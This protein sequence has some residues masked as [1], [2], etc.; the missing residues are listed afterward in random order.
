M[1][2][3]SAPAKIALLGALLWA[4][5]PVGAADPAPVAPG[6]KD[7]AAAKALEMDGDCAAANFD[8]LAGFGYMPPDDGADGKPVP[9]KGARTRSRRTSGHSTAARWRSRATWCR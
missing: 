7:T 1:N 3:V 2:L 6:A 9:A 4:V 5:G 8:R